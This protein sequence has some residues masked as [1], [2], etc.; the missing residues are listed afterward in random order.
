VNTTSGA[1]LLG[2]IGQAAYS[3]AK[4]GL[5]GLTLVQA[6][7]LARYGITANAI[8]PAARTRMTEAVFAQAMAKPESGFDPMDPANIAPLV[9][10]LASEA[11][12]AIT[13]RVFEL[14][15]GRLSLAQGWREGPVA[16]KGETWAA[17]ELVQIVPDLVMRGVP[18][19]KVYGT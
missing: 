13:G 9:V 6:A 12:R 15:G 8:A 17:D 7:E 5:V 16:D 3:T 18:P 2:S 10:Y 11:S 4:A 1:G 19:I 14:S